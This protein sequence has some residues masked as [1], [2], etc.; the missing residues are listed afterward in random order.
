MAIEVTKGLEEVFAGE[1]N[2]PELLKLDPIAE[3]AEDPIKTKRVIGLE[4]IKINKL[5]FKIPIP[6]KLNEEVPGLV[7]G[8]PILK[9]P[10]LPE[11]PIP[12]VELEL[13]V[14]CCPN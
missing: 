7:V 4:S 9:K 12:I 10:P 14:F 8:V 6:P 13:P 2:E 1:L 5:I 3:G 11:F